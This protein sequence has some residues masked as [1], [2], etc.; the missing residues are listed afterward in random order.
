MKSGEW[1]EERTIRELRAINAELLAACKE[2]R[3]AMNQL[4]IIGDPAQ[5]Q[6]DAAID[7]AEKGRAS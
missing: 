4:G 5:F 3:K 7:I 6:L 1:E 2:A